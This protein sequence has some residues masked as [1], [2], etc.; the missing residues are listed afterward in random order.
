MQKYVVERKWTDR[1]R[2]LVTIRDPMTGKSKWAESQGRPIVMN[3]G[4]CMKCIFK[5]A[6]HLVVS[7]VNPAAFGYAGRS[8]WREVLGESHRSTVAIF[9]RR[10]GQ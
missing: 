6:T 7:D 2:S 8:H 5:D 3:S 10:L 4:W 1:P 9:S